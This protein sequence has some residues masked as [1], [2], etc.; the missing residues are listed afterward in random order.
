MFDVE[1][2]KYDSQGLIPAI[3]QDF[4][5]G[6][7]LMM[8][9]MNR[10]SV[11]KTIE[12]GLCTYWSRSRQKLWLKG[13]T[14]G[15]TQAVKEMYFDC[16]NDC[17]LVKVIQKTA[18]C[19]TGKR[20]CFFNKIE[21]GDVVDAGEQVFDAADVY[22]GSDIL[23]KVYAVILDRKKNPKKGSYT[24][25]LLD[26]GKNMIAQKVMEEAS[27]ISI[28]LIDGEPKEVVHE[29]ADTIYHSL[30]A[31]AAMDIPVTDVYAELKKRRKG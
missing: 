29:V 9:F 26:D 24:N 3:V 13:E 10:E 17:L 25:S 6:D 7:V 31:L 12:T 16:D 14:S 18:A 30:V 2:L 11:Q 4:E 19:H 27:E 28:A 22:S 23:D 8:A 21:A 20:S 5:N 1:T 15:N